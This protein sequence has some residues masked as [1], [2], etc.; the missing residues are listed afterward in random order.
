MNYL[1]YIDLFF[2]I[3]LILSLTAYVSFLFFLNKGLNFLGK[4][5]I[6][7]SDN[8][9]K[10]VTI[11][12]PFKNEN[13]ILMRSAVSLSKQKYPKDK[14]EIIY[15]N[16]HSEIINEE[17]LDFVTKQKNFR[18]INNLN[19]TGKKYAITFGIENAKGEI[20]LTT[21]ADSIHNEYW[22]SEMVNSFSNNTVMVSGPV[23]LENSFSLFSKVQ[24]LEFRSLIIVGAALINLKFPRLCSGANLAYRKD[25]F[26][27][28]GGFEGNIDVLSGDDEFLMEKFSFY[29][30]GKIV[31]V[32]TEKAIV[33]SSAKGSFLQF[34]IQ[35][36]RWASKIKRYENKLYIFFLAL[37]FL[38]IM[39]PFLG[40]AMFIT[41]G[42]K[43]FLF[44]I[45]LTLLVKFSTDFFVLKKGIIN[46][47][48]E[49]EID[50]FLITELFQIIYI[51]IASFLGLFIKIKW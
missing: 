17:F 50:N 43:I 28:V 36:I 46:I 44:T 6:N 49:S 25:V 4:D 48:K 45:F 32:N 24:K 11:I 35:R 33:K 22:V 1:N 3:I 13:P 29:N 34:L 2:W 27:Q 21:D 30:K 38:F 37:I 39:Q 26:H 7:Y 31:F 10:H 16:D 9:L 19:Q 51:P 47:Y 14:S 20:I 8:S 23:D 41:T 15:V 12:I 40:V 18:V 5:E 42:E